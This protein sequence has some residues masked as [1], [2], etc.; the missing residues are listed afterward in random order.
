MN[1]L[2]EIIKVLEGGAG[3]GNKAHKGRPGQRGGSQKTGT[4]APIAVSTTKKLV[5]SDPKAVVSF[6][7]DSFNSR[8]GFNAEQTRAE[9]V[10]RNLALLQPVPD[11]FVERLESEIADQ[12]KESGLKTVPVVV[13]SERS[14]T[15]D[16]W[17]H[18][19]YEN[20]MIVFVYHPKGLERQPEKLGDRDISNIAACY[21]RKYGGI[22]VHELGHA[23][24]RFGTGAE[25]QAQIASPGGRKIDGGVLDFKEWRTWVKNN[26]SYYA[27]TNPGELAA[28][29]Y[30]MMKHPDF[31]WQS[32]EV[33]GFVKQIW[34]GQE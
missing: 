29:A 27:A 21:K 34:E 8:F 32:D 17:Q 22:Y 28:E 20:G 13:M 15:M 30:A 4:A 24:D 1:S 23:L 7:A 16:K 19:R 18:A 5:I 33:K 3:S 14:D 9:F 6:L 26:I 11:A 10:S 25:K 31:N 2:G 12:I